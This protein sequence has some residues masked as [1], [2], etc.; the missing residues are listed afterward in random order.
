MAKAAKAFLVHYASCATIVLM[1]AASAQPAHAQDTAR[2]SQAKDAPLGGAKGI[3]TLAIENDMLNGTDANYTHG[4]RLGYLTD[5]VPERVQNAAAYIPTFNQDGELHAQFALTQSIFTPRDISIV[6]P[7]P[8]QRPWAGWLF[9]TV[10]LLSVGRDDAGDVNRL[11]RLSLDIGVVGPAS[12][13]EAVQT[14]WHEVFDFAEPRGWSNQLKN[15]PGVVLNYERSY[16]LPAARWQPL[17]LELDAVP[18]WSVALGNVLTQAATGGTVRFGSGLDRD[19]GAPRIRPSMP[20]GDYFRPATG[21]GLGWYLF[22]GVEG[23]V[24]ARNLFL[25]GNTFVDGPSVD[26]NLLVGDLQVGAALTWGS[27]RLSYTQIYRTREYS[28]QDN[29]SRFGSLALSVAF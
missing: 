7:Q 8:D 5:R 24:V 6:T 23:R 25:D 13:A 19:F 22:A 15:E 20:G 27:T 21:D 2:Q 26:K 28:S 12:G 1:W 29:P 3:F 4:T 9:G 18:H 14:T 10:G 11:D 17:G 16:V